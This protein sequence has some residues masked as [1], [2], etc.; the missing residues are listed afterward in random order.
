[1]IEEILL[2]MDTLS[3]CQPA[4]PIPNGV[5]HRHLVGEIQNEVNVIRHQHSQFAIPNL[6]FVSQ[7]DGIEERPAN[8]WMAKCIAHAVVGTGRDEIHR[9]GRNMRRR[10]VV[11]WTG[12]KKIGYT[13][14]PV[15]SVERTLFEEARD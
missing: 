8:F 2:P 5:R 11:E 1:M 3:L 9:A 6:L 12:H 10:F 14:V 13:T 7:L 4:F 15:G